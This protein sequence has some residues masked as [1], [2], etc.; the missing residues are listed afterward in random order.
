M[1]ECEWRMIYC[2]R[3][4]IITHL[5]AVRKL[6]HQIYSNAKTLII[7]HCVIIGQKFRNFSFAGVE[8]EVLAGCVD[9]STVQFSYV[10]SKGN[11]LAPHSPLS[12]MTT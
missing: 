10:M 1:N 11:L 9:C 12:M 3:M 8:W 5:V 2:V 6:A 4:V 7:T